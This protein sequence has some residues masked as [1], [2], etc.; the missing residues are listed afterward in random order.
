VVEASLSIV[1]PVFNEAE[2][3]RPTLEALRAALAEQ[4]LSYEI[5]WVDDGS[6]DGSAALLD[7]LAGDD[8]R[9]RV[10]HFTRNFGKE[11]ALQAGLERARGD[12]A[13]FLDADLQ[14]PPALVPTMVE[15]W[16]EQGFHVVEAR[17]RER[18]DESRLYRGLVALYYRLLGGATH[19][20]LHGSSDFVLLSREAMDALRALPE[21][22]RFFRGLVH[23][24]GFRTTTVSFDVAPREGGGSRWSASRLLRY[25]LDGIVSFTTLPLVL[26]ALAGLA[27]TLLGSSLGFIALYH[28]ATG[29]AVSGFTTVILMLSI[30]SG[31]I[32]VSLGTIAIYLARLVEEVKGRPLYVVCPERKDDPEDEPPPGGERPE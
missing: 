16:R 2:A 11:A 14:H 20:D 4:P 31:L 1:L 13:V 32:L 27:T 3:I 6:T 28:W 17:K 30:F 26:I 8:P 15:L 9:L 19:G 23:W 18:G 21:R 29:V 12:A 7:R 25:G 5:L 22:N 10:L 24:I